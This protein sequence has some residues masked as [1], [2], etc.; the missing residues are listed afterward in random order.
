MPKGQGKSQ[1]SLASSVSSLFAS[2]LTTY[3]LF[4]LEINT[5]YF[6]GETDLVLLAVRGLTFSVSFYIFHKFFRWL[7]SASPDKN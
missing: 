4:G 5:T 7:Y 6:V 1:S 3:L 2:V